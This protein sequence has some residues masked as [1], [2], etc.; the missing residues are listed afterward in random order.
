MEQ[1]GVDIF[2]LSFLL[3]LLQ[4][5]T[6]SLPVAF[7]LTVLIS[8]PDIQQLSPLQHRLV[9][10]NYTNRLRILKIFSCRPPELMVCQLK[11]TRLNTAPLVESNNIHLVPVVQIS[12]FPSEDFFTF[13]NIF[14]SLLYAG[15]ELRIFI[16]FS[17][18]PRNENVLTLSI[19]L[20]FAYMGKHPSF[21]TKH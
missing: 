4:Y 17:F 16:T 10:S 1:K 18:P 5:V 19:D 9:P 12:N 14:R 15:K 3:R 20:E 13:K 8:C 7:G 6:T 21:L 2:C 11:S